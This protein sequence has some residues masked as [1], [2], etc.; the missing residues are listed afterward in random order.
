MYVVD[1]SVW[2]GRFVPSDTHHSASRE[3]LERVLRVGTPLMGPAILLA[4]VAGAVAR[5]TRPETGHRAVHEIQ[6]LREVRMLPLSLSLAQSAAEVAATLKVKGYDAVYLSLA[7][8][9]GMP[10]ITWD[11]E[12][13]IRGSAVHS[14]REPNEIDQLA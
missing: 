8:Q 6:R 3:W 1:A 9:L 12:L 14:V 7:Q 11:N 10:L 2:V 4:E 5:R 13:R